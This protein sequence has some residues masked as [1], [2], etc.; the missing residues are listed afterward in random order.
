M[1]KI[2]SYEQAQKIKKLEGF[3]VPFKHI[4]TTFFT[5]DRAYF[6]TWVEELILTK[7]EEQM[8]VK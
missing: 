1:T 7:D 8:C 5:F 4:L 6:E 3:E 2:H